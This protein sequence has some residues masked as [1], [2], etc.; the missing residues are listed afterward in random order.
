MHDAAGRH[1]SQSMPFNEPLVSRVGA[2]AFAPARVLCSCSWKTVISCSTWRY[3]PLPQ[4]LVEKERIV[5]IL[6]RRCDFPPL[7]ATPAAP[8][9]SNV[10]EASVSYSRRDVKQGNNC[11]TEMKRSAQGSRVNLPQKGIWDRFHLKGK[12]KALTTLVS[13]RQNTLDLVHLRS[14]CLRP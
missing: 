1:T 13:L 14:A 8:A 12:E 5:Q 3:S 4:P 2:A 11:C 9:V 6:Q 7:E 10:W